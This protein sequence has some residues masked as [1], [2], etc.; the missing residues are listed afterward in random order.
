MFDHGSPSDFNRAVPVAYPGILFWG[1]GVQQIELRTQ[2]RENRDLEAVAPL[3][4][5]SGGGCNLYFRLF[6]MTTNLFVI[7][8][9]KQLRTEGVLEFYWLFLNILGCW[10]PKFSNF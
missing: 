6:F 5:G 9:V 4:R 7:V 3:V 10:C 1:R 8:N 2:D